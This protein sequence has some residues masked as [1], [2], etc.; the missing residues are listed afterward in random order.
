MGGRRYPTVISLFFS[1]VGR[2]CHHLALIDTRMLRAGFAQSSAYSRTILVTSG[3]SSI[4][5]SAVD[6]VHVGFASI[7]FQ[8]LP[9]IILSVM[10]LASGE[11]I[12]K[13]LIALLR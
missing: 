10:K 13:F 5:P 8:G 1:A 7:C 6:A 4:L 12:G 2:S 11:A 9:V 3:F